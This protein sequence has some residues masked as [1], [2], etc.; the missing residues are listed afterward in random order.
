M[1]DSLIQFDTRLFYCVNSHHSTFFDWFFYLFTTHLSW[2]IVLVLF[3][4]LVTLRREARS[5]WAVLLGIAL[6]FLLSDRISVL[7]FK[8]VVCRLRPCHALPDV[9]MFRVGCGGQYGF[10]SSHAANSFSLALFLALRYGF[11]RRKPSQPS[12][13]FASHASP[14]PSC[15]WL[16]PVLAFLW[17]FTTSLS[18][19][20]LGKHYPGDIL[21]GA[22]V[23]LA[24]GALVYW[25]L[26][27]IPATAK[28]G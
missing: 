2:A 23:G 9:H 26:Q 13:A 4:C 1:L 16:V 5:W 25:L 14:R 15:G 17:A 27:K 12:Q 6:C 3:F 10:V 11:R 19:V 24:I 8:D 18:R 20:Y 28:Q 7:C 21:C 22:L